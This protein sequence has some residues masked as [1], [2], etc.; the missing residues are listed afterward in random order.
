[1]SDQ[2]D[3][4]HLPRRRTSD[5]PSVELL[6]LVSNS[7][8]SKSSC[9]RQLQFDAKTEEISEFSS[10]GMEVSCVAFGGDTPETTETERLS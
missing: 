2:L 4:T 8:S 6:L 7:K 10:R 1:M 3:L 5:A 9:Q